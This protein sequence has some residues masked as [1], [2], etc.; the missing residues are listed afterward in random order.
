[1]VQM[2]QANAVLYWK[3]LE[4]S[5]ADPR[6]FGPRLCPVGSFSLKLPRYEIE[7][8]RCAKQ[9]LVVVAALY[10]AQGIPWGFA[11]ITLA[12]L[13]A[14]QG[15][16]AGAIGKLLAAVVLPWS[17]KF[18]GGPLVD[19]IRLPGGRRRP[20]I[21]LA[22]MG[23]VATLIGLSQVGLAS[24]DQLSAWL[25]AHN[26]FA[27]LQDVATDALAVDVMPERER[28]RANG[29]MYGAKYG[30]TAIGGAGLALLIQHFD[31]SVGTLFQAVV[32]GSISAVPLL[33]REPDHDQSTKSSTT[34]WIISLGELLHSRPFWWTLALC[35]VI[36]LP[37]AL[38]TPLANTLFIEQYGWT[39]T[40]WAVLNGGP[41]VTAGL[42]GAVGG[43]FLVSRYGPGRIGIL[44]ASA[45]AG[46]MLIFPL[47]PELFH[48]KDIVSLTL[49]AQSA[50]A[51]AVTVGSFTL[52]MR[53]APPVLAASCFTALM[54]M[55]NL[56]TTSG[57]WAA[58]QMPSEP[59][60]AWTIVA[61][62]W[63]VV[64]LL[65]WQAD[66]SAQRGEL[67]TPSGQ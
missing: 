21:L 7:G 61:V 55:Q 42:M 58:N 3:C 18:V 25:L 28:G 50:A 43:G 46:T 22:Q 19:G 39:A 37:S 5:K 35:L 8:P 62:I 17:F 16:D 64:G 29:I 36:G 13:L 49:V 59:G 10:L 33:L 24:P 47:C 65:S 48:N 4:T 56:S 45:H 12:A 9:R 54:A 2:V 67:P 27:A 14:E 34:H 60:T 11:T 40:S 44:A 20:W 15:V 63:C 23:M 52:A 57:Y 38:L 31:W 66:R 30:G 53:V 6:Q 51:G 32:V 41:G 1:M 26:V